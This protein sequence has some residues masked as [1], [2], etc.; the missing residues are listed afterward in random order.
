MNLLALAP[1]VLLFQEGEKIDWK[2]DY[3]AALKEAQ[4]SGR[5][6]VVHFSGPDALACKMMNE[7]TFANAGVIGHS[8]KTFVN[9]SVVLEGRHPLAK[10]FGIE[11][12]PTTFLVTAAGE[13]V[14][15]WEGYLGPED[16]TK[17]LDAAVS[18]HKGIQGLE[19][20][21]KADPDSLELN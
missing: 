21:L 2:K 15:K 13:R 10:Q 12:I 7:T 17:G 8:N 20:K 14:R 18:A 16:Y 4:K 11:A 3:E 19:A 5:Y 1:L 6:V 9:V